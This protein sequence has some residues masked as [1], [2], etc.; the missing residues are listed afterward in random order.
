[1]KGAADPRDGTDAGSAVAVTRA[2]PAWCDP[3]LAPPG[4]ADFFASRL[5]YD[6]LLGHAVPS[7]AR[8]A[9]LR[10]HGG[11]VLLPLLDRRSSLTSPYS[12]EWR[13]LLH[14]GADPAAWHAAG[15]ALAQLRRYAP[16]LRLEAFDPELPVMRALLEGAGAAGLKILRFRHFGSW[17]EVLPEGEGWEAYLARRPPAMRSTIQRKLARAGR[18]LRFELLREAGP[19]LDSGI[20]AYEAVRAASWKPHEPFPDF[21]AH[22]MRATAAA[23]QLRLGVLRDAASGAPVAAQYWVVG[24]GRAYLLKLCH[25]EA[26]RAASPGTA[27]TAMMIRSLLQQ[28]EVRELDFG[29][30]DDP[31]KQL[32]VGTR[33]QR[34]GVVIASPW[35][36]EGLAA[37][38]R[39]RGA[40]LL[41]RWRGGDP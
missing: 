40:A 41:R 17:H 27:L 13:P 28:D 15:G 24:G 37:I 2:L 31:Y 26:S 3:A 8:P 20:G 25:T 6:T 7:A 19:G 18:T 32:W 22:L 10:L 36:P 9:V 5:W 39:H 34:C 35:H 1:M 23:G 21:D 33:R 29:R 14:P 11:A 16:P 30:G 38:A 12:L 4:S